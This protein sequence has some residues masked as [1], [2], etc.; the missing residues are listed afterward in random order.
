MIN[1]K[2]STTSKSNI[3]MWYELEKGSAKFNNVHDYQTQL[4]PITKQ[5]A[6]Y[7]DEGNETVYKSNLKVSTLTVVDPDAE[8]EGIKLKAFSTQED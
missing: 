8:S 2:Y 4:I 1:P 3:D 5:K 7:D 6:Y